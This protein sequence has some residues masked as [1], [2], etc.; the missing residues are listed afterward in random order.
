MLQDYDEVSRLWTEKQKGLEA[1]F[2]TQQL[3]EALNPKPLTL[4]PKHDGFRKPKYGP[5][6]MAWEFFTVIEC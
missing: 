3:V 5:F 4:K 6:S 1:E 2:E